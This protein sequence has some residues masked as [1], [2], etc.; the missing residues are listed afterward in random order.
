MIKYIIE[1]C[2]YWDKKNGNMYYKIKIKNNK[3]KIIYEMPNFT[4]G[5]GSMRINHAIKEL[6]KLGLWQEEN[7][8]NWELIHKLI[9]EAPIIE[10]TRQKDIKEF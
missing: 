4:Y 9:Y 2:E 6:I 7:K 5:Q 3:Q 1:S 10:I 8:T